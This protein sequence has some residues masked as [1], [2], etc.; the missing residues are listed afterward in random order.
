MSSHIKF[1]IKQRDLLQFPRTNEWMNIHFCQHFTGDGNPPANRYCRTCP[2]SVEAC[3]KLWQLVVNLA[4][5]HDGDPI[6]LPKTRAL[7]S[8]HPH[9]PNFIRLEINVR[10][11]LPKEDFLHY[12]ATGHAKMGRKG[13][14][15]NPKSSP[16][17]TRQEPY[18]HAI[19]ELLGGKD[20][21]EIIAVK[22]VQNTP[23][24]P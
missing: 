12:I 8:P 20:I 19:A 10:W 7:M 17:M 3:D 6:S 15:Q 21:P 11:N 9:N 18:V 16:S 1:H 13:Q 5:S 23:H 22:K 2:H 4:N 24:L 14:R